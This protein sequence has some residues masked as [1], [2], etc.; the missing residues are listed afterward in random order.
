MFFSNTGYEIDQVLIDGVNDPAAASAASYTFTNVTA[1]HTIYVSF[2]LTGQQPQYTITAS[3]GEHGNISPSGNVLVDQGNSQTFTFTPEND[4]EIN[5]V[6]V[7]GVNDPAAASAGSYTFGN[8]TANHTIY[9]S[10]KLIQHTI[11][12]SAGDHGGISPAGNVLVDQG[13]SQTFTF[14]P[15]NDYE[16]NQVLIDNVDNPAAASAGSYTFANVI[17][18]HTIYVSFKLTGQQPQQ[19]TITASAD[20]NG[21]I[22]PDGITTVPEGEDQAFMFPPNAGYKIDQVLVD[23]V[24]DPAAVSAGS[25]T[26]ANVRADHTIRVTFEEETIPLGI[27]IKVVNEE[28]GVLSPAFNDRI[29]SYRLFLNCHQ[30]TAQIRVRAQDPLATI[31]IAGETFGNTATKNLVQN[32]PGQKD[33]TITVQEENSSPTTYTIELIRPFD[34]VVIPIWDD[35]LSVI[36]IPENNGGYHF[37]QYQW[38]RDKLL[39]EIMENDTIGNLYLPDKNNSDPG[40]TVWLMTDNDLESCGCRTASTPPQNAPIRVYPNPATDKITIEDA[41]WK[42]GNQ[43][44]LRNIN[45]ILVKKQEVASPV[46]E[47]NITGL[48]RGIYLLYVNGEVVK[49]IKN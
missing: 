12:A 8:V 18:D 3:V 38:Y 28:E 4:Y 5:Q 24:N 23:G 40:Y 35:I 44:E 47:L 9:V 15:E 48:M 2:K 21:S 32:T 42:K 33:V 30:N 20:P 13:N 49:I 11:T 7:D 41:Q 10:F 16:I 36:N 37:I 45:G 17:A 39:T 34:D 27:E 25:Y 46:T 14:T 29:T 26:F 31:N 6:L 1:N 22:W 43:L 19:Y